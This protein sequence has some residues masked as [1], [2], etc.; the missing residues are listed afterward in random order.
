MLP[1][2]LL[3]R[4]PPMLE[5]VSRCETLRCNARFNL[6][7]NDEYAIIDRVNDAKNNQNQLMELNPYGHQSWYMVRIA[8]VN[9]SNE[10]GK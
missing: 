1:L 7:G 6:A 5:I 3:S 8:N 9:S 4:T 10:V 2:T